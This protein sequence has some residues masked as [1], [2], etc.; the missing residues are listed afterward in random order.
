MQRER[1]KKYNKETNKGVEKE[2]I[3]LD[4]KKTREKIISK[5]R[6]VYD[7]GLYPLLN[8]NTNNGSLGWGEEL[9]A[10]C[11]QEKDHPKRRARI[12]N[13]VLHVKS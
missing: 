9:G 2:P 10:S 4:V 11:K 6:Q 1:S 8:K 12:E 13:G 7:Q 3:E 5:G